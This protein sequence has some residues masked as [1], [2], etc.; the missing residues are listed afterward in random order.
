M[1]T[2]TPYNPGS[3]KSLGQH[4]LTDT[5]VL[6]E[7]IQAADLTLNDIVVEVGPGRGILTKRLVANAGQIFTIE[8]DV[9]LANLIETQLDYPKNLTSIIGD[10][11]YTDINELIDPDSK[12]KMVSN[13]PYYA[14]NPIV[15]RFLELPPKPQVM[16]VMVQEEVAKSMVA[17]PGQMGILSVA[18]Q[19]YAKTQLVCKVPPQAFYPIPKVSSAVV[20]MEV[21]PESPFHLENTD[22]FFS[23]VKAGF[24]APRKKLHNS[25]SNGLNIPSASAIRLIEMSG[26]DPH[27]RPASLSIAEWIALYSRWLESD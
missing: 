2:N 18:V 7:I 21:Y 23:L 26:I 22:A 13:L 12:F 16:V 10:A 25:L 27:C 6:D 15:R 17:E 19:Y 9:K 20:K 5:T 4:F 11:R 24:R 3:P 1:S 14:A 8:L